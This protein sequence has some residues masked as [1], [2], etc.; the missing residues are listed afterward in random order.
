[1]GEAAGVGGGGFG[2]SEEGIVEMGDSVEDVVG[3]DND[4]VSVSVSLPDEMSASQ[5]SATGFDFGFEASFGALG[6]AFVESCRCERVVATS[7]G[8]LGLCTVSRRNEWEE[9]G[10]RRKEEGFS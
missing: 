10:G 5:L 7:G 1:M 4:V 2:R 9:G 6:G 8:L 3:A